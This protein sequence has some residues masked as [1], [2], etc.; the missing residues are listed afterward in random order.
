MIKIKISFHLERIAFL[1]LE[2]QYPLSPLSLR[3][4][5]RISAWS[6]LME[7][8][9]CF[10]LFYAIK[11][12]KL[13]LILNM[14]FAKKKATKFWFD[15]SDIVRLVHKLAA[16]VQQ[17]HEF[18]NNEMTLES[19]QDL[20][21]NQKS[22]IKI[23]NKI[24]CIFSI[25]SSV[26]LIYS[27]YVNHKSK[28]LLFLAIWLLILGIYGLFELRKH[29]KLTYFKNS[30]SEKQN[31]ENAI[32]VIQKIAKG[33]YTQNEN[34]YSFIYQKSWWRVDYKVTIFADDN[35]IAINAEGRGSSDSGFIDFGASKK[36]EQM[37]ANILIN[38]A[39]R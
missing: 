37:I 6:G 24:L 18:K 1:Y 14:T 12:I 21:E 33:N 8:L 36:T 23:F 4:A 13:Y 20:F 9:F 10:P 38:N 35:L 15:W 16:N 34:S 39:R 11:K 19:F 3:F 7:N 30:F 27:V 5:A 31:I 25:N 29:Y 26:F 32:F 2:M 28:G 22:S 17:N